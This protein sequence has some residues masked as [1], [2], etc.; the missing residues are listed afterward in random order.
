VRTTSKRRRARI[1]IKRRV[2]WLVTEL[3]RD[4]TAA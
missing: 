2:E 1:A 4:A 3:D